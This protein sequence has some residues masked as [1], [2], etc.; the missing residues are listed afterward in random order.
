M[1]SKKKLADYT[2]E[3]HESLWN[4]ALYLYENPEIGFQE[5][6]SSRALTDYL[7]EHGFEQVTLGVAGLGTAFIATACPSGIHE[8]H[9]DILAEY[10][11][12]D[13]GFAGGRE[14]RIAHACGHNIIAATGTGAAV[15]LLKLMKKEQIPGTLRIVGT[16]AEEGGGGKIILQNAGIFDDTDF[17]ILL[18]PT[19]GT[20]KIA[21][22]CKSI[23]RLTVT[24]HGRIAHAGNHRQKG[25]NAQDA[26]VICYTAI[27]CLRHRLP[28]DLQV[29]AQIQDLPDTNGIIPDHAGMSI[30]TR[31]FKKTDL[32]AAIPQIKNCIQAGALAT[33]CTVEIVESSPYYGRVC[34]HTLEP[35]LRQNFAL[36]GEEILPGMVD[37]SG[38]EDFG[39]LIREVPGIMPY[40]SLCLTHRVSL[41][42]L[43]YLELVH[44][45]RAKEVVLMG[46]RVLAYT[47]LDVLK[48]PSI[49]LA[50]KAELAAMKRHPM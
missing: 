35:V 26:A 46:S 19:S 22:R 2:A 5:Y 24:Y 25:I 48:D 43:E 3:L 30:T 40:P 14:K 28:D 39:N 18:H 10:D 49:L 4:L 34:Y 36:L 23:S 11:A 44:S 27:G 8:P 12:L 21:G 50:A 1:E 32:D 38:G 9:V 31:C 16:P 45:K 41:H 7:K 37:D 42:T 20:S 33:G 47:V 6:K 29:F 17:M 13:L 15:A